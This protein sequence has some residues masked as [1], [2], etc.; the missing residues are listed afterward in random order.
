MCFFYLFQASKFD[1]A[2][3]E[4]AK[5]EL[6][7]AAAFLDQDESTKK[8]IDE[9]FAATFAAVHSSGAETAAA[10]D[11]TKKVAMTPSMLWRCGGYQDDVGWYAKV[12]KDQAA[13]DTEFKE[14]VATVLQ[15]DKPC[16]GHIVLIFNNMYIYATL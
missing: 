6:T 9:A 12:T 14:A 1:K 8:A 7:M 13:R 15:E 16:F 10:L 11:E 2:A 4:A 5:A 3:L